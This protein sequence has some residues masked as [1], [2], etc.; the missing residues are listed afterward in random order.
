MR[1]AR[2]LF[3]IDQEPLFE[4][5]SFE[6]DD[7]DAEQ[8]WDDRYDD[9]PPA[10]ATAVTREAA[11]ENSARIGRGLRSRVLVVV[12]AIGVAGFVGSRLT[13]VAGTPTVPPR[14]AATSQPP[15]AVAPL[16]DSVPALRPQ[17]TRTRR[18]R[19]GATSRRAAARRPR[20]A[21]R[22]AARAM[23]ASA[24]V[25]APL[26]A[27]PAPVPRY[28]PPPPPEPHGFSGEFF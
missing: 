3:E 24:P 4:P 28:A 13:Q 20:A 11:D 6:G 10:A 21:A 9:L 12:A 27:V 8:S 26:P 15:S 2:S 17:A 5:G 25:T 16:A 23:Q 18:A 22:P 1:R 19:P 14:T 7:G